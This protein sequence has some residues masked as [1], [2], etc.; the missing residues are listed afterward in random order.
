M[1]GTSNEELTVLA[2]AAACEAGW[3][4]GLEPIASF[5][6]I[7]QVP[8][9]VH[10]SLFGSFVYGTPEFPLWDVPMQTIVDRVE[11]GAYQAAPARVFRFEEIR[12]A[13]RLMEASEA[14]GKLVVAIA[15]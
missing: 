10:Y 15:A 8:S 6:P 1:K 7:M 14:N 3:L 11:S 12:E 5:N 2:R 13:H 9:G 4:G